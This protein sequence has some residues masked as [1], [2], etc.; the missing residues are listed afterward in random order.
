MEF[1]RAHPIPR[2]YL[3]CTA[4]WIGIPE[5]CPELCWNC[6]SL[7]LSRILDII[8]VIFFSSVFLSRMF[9]KLLFNH[10]DIIQSQRLLFDLNVIRTFS[11]R[12]SNFYYSPSLGSENYYLYIGALMSIDYFVVLNNIIIQPRRLLFNL[13]VIR[14][15]SSRISNFYYSPSPGSDI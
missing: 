5:L 12:I 10:E 7:F 2:E 6:V 8:I 13:N 15:F 3:F 9:V 14:T 1:L 11:S 4:Q